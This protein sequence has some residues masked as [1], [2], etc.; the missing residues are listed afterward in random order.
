[1]TK[2]TTNA[3]RV[4]FAEATWRLG[5]A[6]SPV[7]LA[8]LLGATAPDAVVATRQGLRVDLSFLAGAE[9]DVV[10][11]QLTVVESGRL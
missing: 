10:L 8:A 3:T 6:A 11:P 1:M 5:L 2:N 9:A 7:E 4:D